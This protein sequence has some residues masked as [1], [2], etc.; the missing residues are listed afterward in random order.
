MR[1]DLLSLP[2]DA[3]APQAWALLWSLSVDA[4]YPTTPGQTAADWLQSLDLSPRQWRLIHHRIQRHTAQ[5]GD[6]NA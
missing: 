2:A 1:D 6:R 3:P 4:L 5:E